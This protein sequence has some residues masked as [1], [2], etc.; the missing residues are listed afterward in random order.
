MNLKNYR[1]IG[2]ID[3]DNRL[4]SVMFVHDSIEDEVIAGVMWLY[5][6]GIIKRLAEERIRLGVEN[7]DIHPVH[8][9]NLLKKVVRMN[10]VMNTVY[11]E[12]IQVVV[13]HIV[14][15]KDWKLDGGKKISKKIIQGMENNKDYGV[16]VIETEEEKEV[17]E[18][19]GD[20]INVT[21]VREKVYFADVKRD[22]SGQAKGLGIVRLNS[23]KEKMI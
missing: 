22:S 8:R 12:R 7:V 13:G 5:E 6:Q 15:C 9:L 1:S 11:R 3:G 4:I 23:E 14:D 2:I 17:Y 21:V 10:P 20:V 18:M 19:F 16:R